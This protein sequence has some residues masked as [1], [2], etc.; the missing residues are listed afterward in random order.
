MR[1]VTTGLFERC[2]AVAAMAV[3]IAIAAP[4]ALAQDAPAPAPEVDTGVDPP[5]IPEAPDAGLTPAQRLEMKHLLDDVKDGRLDAERRRRA[6]LILL[7]RDWPEATTQ[8]RRLLLATTDRPTREAVQGA[9]AD[10]D[11][12]DESFIAPLL[13]QLAGDDADTRALAPAA[14]ARFD[15]A[16]VTAKLLKIASDTK[17][18][19]AVRTGAI[20][21][22][23]GHRTTGVLA[24]LAELTA[25][26]DEAVREATYTALAELTGRADIAP[27]ARDWQAYAARVA[28]AAEHDWRAAWTR[29]LARN[30][31]RLRQEMAERTRRLS[32]AYNL[33]YNTSDEAR[34]PALLATMLGDDTVELRLLAVDLIERR[35]LDAQPIDDA[36]RAAMRGALSD[37]GSKVRERVA[38]LL[39]D[40]KDAAGARRA[41]LLLAD[42]RDPAVKAAYLSLMARLPGKEA[43]G[44]ALEAMGDALLRSAAAGV[45]VAAAEAELLD[46]SQTTAAL[47]ATREQLSGAKAPD[48]QLI[49]LLGRLGKNDDAK[50][51]RAFLDHDLPAVRVAAAEQ[52]ALDRWPID[53]LL[54]YL[55]D[56]TLRE[57]A[58]A[59]AARRGETAKELNA[60]LSS[61]PDDA[62]TLETWRAAVKA[63]AGRLTAK[64]LAAVDD[65]LTKRDPP[66]AMHEAVL[67]AAAAPHANGGAEADPEAAEARR[68]EAGL[69]LGGY[70][71]RANEPAKAEAALKR[72]AD[73]KDLSES[74]RGRLAI[75]QVRLLLAQGQID[76]ASAATKAALASDAPPDIAPLA[77]AWLTAAERAATDER[78]AAAGKLAKAVDDA[79]GAKMSPESRRRLDA[80]NERLAPA[81]PAPT[82]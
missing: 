12:P 29:N 8:L 11:R 47:T 50:T 76:D 71:T 51:L 6:A 1:N 79:L 15:R 80:L 23:G 26:D 22:L 64:D 49:R 28:A 69:R 21:A 14:L 54:S 53:P 82:P 9:I 75:A 37:P 81:P 40:L 31:A 2:G 52:I 18:D 72:V 55:D 17:A 32:E 38:L 66:S 74:H 25:D 70:Y 46:D 39:R 59:A 42:E 60:L 34:R 35:V 5:L 16:D 57:V 77:D 41:V 30:G 7:H 45:L 3:L 43:V 19:A 27:T 63:I 13:D 73:R 36:L 24:A 67:I 62:A 58:I 48:P 65:G 20:A 4:G 61:E 68:R 33:L 78:P 56:T 10:A 44:P